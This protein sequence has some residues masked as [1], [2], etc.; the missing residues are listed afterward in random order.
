MRKRQTGLPGRREQ[1]I[2]LCAEQRLGKLRERRTLVAAVSTMEA[3]AEH[4][5]QQQMT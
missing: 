1:I 2:L 5:R 3:A 4:Y